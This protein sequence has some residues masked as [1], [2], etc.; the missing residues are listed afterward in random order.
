M[1]TSLTVSLAWSNYLLIADAAQV[2][3][4]NFNSTVTGAEEVRTIVVTVRNGEYYL[5]GS[6]QP[7]TLQPGTYLFQNIPTSHPMAIVGIFDESQ[8]T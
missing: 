8:L 6:N 7:R 4:F 5:D 2:A 3:L 1:T